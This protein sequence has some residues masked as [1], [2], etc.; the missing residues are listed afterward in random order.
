M[1]KFLILNQI[2]IVVFPIESLWKNSLSRVL[3]TDL[4]YLLLFSRYKRVKM[5]P[6]TQN[7]SFLS[8]I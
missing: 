5:G 4:V 2:R 6:N 3:S 1:V 7:V 8:Q